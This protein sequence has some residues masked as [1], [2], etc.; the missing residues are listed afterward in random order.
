MNKLLTVAV[1][2]VTAAL[3]TV[4][5]AQN[6]P[7]AGATSPASP[8]KILL[9]MEK[10]YATCQSYRD[11]G[12]VREIS[13]T[14]GGQFGSDQPFVTA[15]VRPG[16][17]R[18]Q[19]TDR[20]LGERS[21]NYIVWCDGAEVRTWWD[22]RPG[23]R[24]PSSLGAALD[25]AAGISGGASVRVPGML[26]PDAVGAGPPLV[27]LVRIDDGDDRGVLCFRLRGKSQPTPYTLK[28]G[29]RQVT[30]KDE[31][32]TLWIDRA[33]FLLRKVEQARTFETYHSVTTTTYTPEIDVPMR[34]G[35]LAFGAPQGS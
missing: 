23:V 13:M 29:H 4:V 18:F 5:A 15:F 28:M 3:A 35:E 19:F 34:E 11:Q 8:E 14:D 26:L 17:F 24:Q 32:L 20:G 33:T 25:A 22:A 27:D 10:T 31:A 9:K 2:L 16:H 21:S 30:V 12:E 7:G 1:P 6:A